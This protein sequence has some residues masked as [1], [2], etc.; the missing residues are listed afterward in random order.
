[1]PAH[2]R[3]PLDGDVLRRLIGE[4]RTCAEAVAMT[5]LDRHALYSWAKRNGLAWASAAHKWGGR[6]AHATVRPAAEMLPA[7]VPLAQV[8]LDP[9]EAARI[10]RDYGLR[11][12]PCS[13][14]VV[15][16]GLSGMTPEDEAALADWR[17][18]SVT[19]PPATRRRR[20]LLA[21]WHGEGLGYAEIIARW[22]AAS[23]EVI[24]TGQLSNDLRMHREG[25][26]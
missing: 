17:R 12:A 11:S 14:T 22:R 4:G 13:V 26:A 5:G 21:R 23:G 3:K 15:P 18:A 6:S 25:R 10:A 7:Q 19:I 9:A 16:Q 20:A 1:M 2:A 8:P 24:G